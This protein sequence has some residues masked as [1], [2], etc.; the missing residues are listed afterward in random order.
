MK[1]VLFQTYAQL[2]IQKQLPKLRKVN[3]KKFCSFF[4]KYAK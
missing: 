2:K 1:I 4:L 3:M